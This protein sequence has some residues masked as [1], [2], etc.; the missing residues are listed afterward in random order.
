M[1][2][3]FLEKCKHVVITSSLR[4]PTYIFS[5]LRWSNVRKRFRLFQLLLHALHCLE[6]VEHL[7]E[8]R[9][10]SFS[11]NLLVPLLAIS[12][13]THCTSLWT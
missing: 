10:Q 7:G 6:C 12:H 11:L 2:K 3:R 8:L 5:G 9:D 4:G 13:H 1:E